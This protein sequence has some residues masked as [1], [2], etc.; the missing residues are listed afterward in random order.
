MN[1]VWLEVEQKLGGWVRGQLLVM[2]VM[3]V[4]A[5]VGFWIIGLPNP[6]LLGVLAGIGELIPMVGPFIGFAPAVLVALGIDPWTALLVVVYAIVV[7]QIE[8]NFLVPRIMGHSVGVSPLTVVLGILIG[9]ILYGLP[10]AFLAVPIAGAIQVIV[11]H[12][13]GLEDPNRRP[14]T[15]RPWPARRQPRRQP[16]PLPGAGRRGGRGRPRGRRGGAG[17]QH[18]RSDPRGAGS[19]A[20]R[21]ERH[22]RPSRVAAG[23][24]HHPWRQSTRKAGLR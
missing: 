5:G 12:A 18:A 14:R 22:D 4:M 2:G 9:A 21:P 3:G 13:V 1:A 11:A 15:G 7:Q 8:G 16:A 19:R 10:G 24:T 20:R 6:V 17:G 23:G